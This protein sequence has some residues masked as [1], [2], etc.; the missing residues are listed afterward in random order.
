[1]KREGFIGNFFKIVLFMLEKFAAKYEPVILDI[2][3]DENENKE[4]IKG[5]KIIHTPGHSM[6]SLS[7]L[8]LAKEAVFTGDALTG[9]PVPGLPMR[10]GCSDHGQ[11]LVSV[12]Y[13]SELHFNTALFGHG[14]PV[15]DDAA[16]VVKSVL[17]KV[18]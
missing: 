2:P 15:K 18:C 13:I 10:A 3:F 8:C 9:I 14:I 7:Y 6:G 4:I 1:M 11:A 12:K 17:Q 16:A 5:I